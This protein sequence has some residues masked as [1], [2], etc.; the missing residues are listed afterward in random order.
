M[1]GRLQNR[2]VERLEIGLMIGSNEVNRSGV[3]LDSTCEKFCF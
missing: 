1:K 3:I 2:V